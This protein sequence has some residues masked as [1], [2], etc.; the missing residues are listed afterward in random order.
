MMPIV[1]V[2]FLAEAVRRD[3]SQKY[4]HCPVAGNSLP[5]VK[6]ESAELCDHC[7]I[8]ERIRFRVKQSLLS[9]LLRPIGDKH[10]RRGR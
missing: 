6:F 8:Y 3:Q 9:V 10:P 1:D 7:R 5:T 2:R 4:H